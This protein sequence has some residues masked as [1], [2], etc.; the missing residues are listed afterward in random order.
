ME[1]RENQLTNFDDAFSAAQENY[2][3]AENMDDTD[4]PP[5]GTEEAEPVADAGQQE[6]GQAEQAADV[7]ET[8]AL[9][10][11]E[12]N[13][14][15]QGV[16]QENAQLRQ[17]NAQLQELLQ[18]MNNQNKAQVIEETMP[19][20]P[21]LDFSSLAFA[22]EAEQRAAMARYSQ[23]MIEY[24]KQAILKD[25]APFV[26]QAKKGQLEAEKSELIRALAVVP[27]LDGIGDMTGQLDRIIAN[28]RVLQNDDI[29]LD[30]KYITAYAIAKGVEAMNNPYKPP[31]T[32]EL[33]NMYNS[34]PEFK[35]AVEKQRLA[36]IKGKTADVPALSGSS[37]IG[38]AAPTMPEKAK[39]WDE[40]LANAKKREYLI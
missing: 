4:V 31:T 28:N 15:L 23:D 21:Q 14:Q 7:A 3:A 38:N 35:E 17:Q 8:A 39:N 25:I 1:E 32:E 19:Q 20:I 11:Q 12:A 16:M 6:A 27:E 37:G 13:N 18:Q 36:E 30:E 10:A 29:P 24:S 26:E 22:D 34:N 40:A 2:A 5:E 9:A 33:M